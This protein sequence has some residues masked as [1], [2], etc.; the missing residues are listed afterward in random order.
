[1]DS[2]IRPVAAGDLPALEQVIAATGLFPPDLLAGMLSPHLRG[3]GEE[4]WLAAD[5]AA[6]PVGLLYAA[7]ERMT[8]GCWNLLLIAVRPDRQGEGIGAALVAR[9]EALLP[10]RGARILLVETSGLADFDATRAFYRRRGFAEEA[11]IRD[12]YRD[13]EDKIV[14]RKAL[15]GR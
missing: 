12:F 4:I 6:G 11:R 8:E 1:M 5:A 2:A 13:G 3:E 10:A 7:P 15:A 9:L 14:F